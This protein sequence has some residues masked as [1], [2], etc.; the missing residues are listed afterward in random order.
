[1]LRSNNT[2]LAV[3]LGT[4]H[5]ARLFLDSMVLGSVPIRLLIVVLAFYL[6]TQLYFSR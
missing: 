2:E 6:D 5:V 1:M 3:L 4:V